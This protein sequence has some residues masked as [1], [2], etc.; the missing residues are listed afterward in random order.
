VKDKT[1][2]YQVMS[3][4]CWAM[5]T[6]DDCFGCEASFDTLEEAV[7]Y[8]R[9][10]MDEQIEGDIKKAQAGELTTPEQI[11]EARSQ[12]STF[13]WSYSIHNPADPAAEEAFK[14]L[15]YVTDRLTEIVGRRGP[16]SD[17]P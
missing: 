14:F 3:Y 9:R 16:L 4:D 10:K 6:D 17:L 13:G 8:C 12:I 11:K 1:K 15:D 7:A 2:P 5:Y